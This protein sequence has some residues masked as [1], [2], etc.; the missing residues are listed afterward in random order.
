MKNI[1][2]L[3]AS[4]T[5]GV[6]LWFFRDFYQKEDIKEIPWP[7]TQNYE[8]DIFCK[9]NRFSTLLSHSLNLKEIN[10]SRAGGSPALSLHLLKKLNIDDIDYVIFEFSSIFSFF[11]SYFFEHEIDETVLP[12]TPSEIESFLTNNKND[13]PDLRDK[14]EKWLIKF[15]AEEFTSETFKTIKNFI[16]DN[17][18]LKF[19]I[20]I[21]RGTGFKSFKF[22]T[23]EYSWIL[24]YSPKF[25]IQK[26]K[27]NILVEDYLVENNLTV[28]SE[29]K[30]YN[31]IKIPNRI[32]DL[33]PSLNGHKKLFEL[34]KNYIDEKN[35]TNS[36]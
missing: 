16:S 2:F 13:R 9:K 30:N 35:S 12:K 6:G 29:F 28:Y 4:N 1:V 31:K 5:Y 21:W 23:D 20:L 32:P 34:L 3:G 15:D 26:N 7:Y 33:H 36:W 22:D 25:S 10:L 24:N 17:P 18:K 27:N 14:I 11:D 8:D 19:I